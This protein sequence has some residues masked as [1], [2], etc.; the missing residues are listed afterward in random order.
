MTRACN[1]FHRA[2]PDFRT[3]Y[4][5]G[6]GGAGRE[7]AWLAA[8]SWGESVKSI[9]LVDR[10]EFIC[11]PVNGIPVQMLSDVSA[12]TDVRFVI[13]VGDSTLRRRAA[14]ACMEIGLRP[15]TLVHPRVEA[16]RSVRLGEGVVVCAGSILT[17]NVVVEQHT[18]INVACT[19][20][21]DVSIGE[22]TTLSPGVHVAGH[23]TIGRNVFVGTGANII[24]GRE[25]ARLAIGDGA[26]IAAGAC[27]TKS[28]DPEALMTGVPA[29]RRR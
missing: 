7:V 4:I 18:H 1:P 6:A 8:Q 9:F 20:S 19:I 22:F 21:H 24:N 16:S 28:V 29:T 25:G 12:S 3:L 27:V 14:S 15:V 10:P 5:F 2:D 11:A 17:T 13:A 23:V 26:V